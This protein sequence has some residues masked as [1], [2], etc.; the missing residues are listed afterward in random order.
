[1]ARIGNGAKPGE[2]RRLGKPNKIK[3]EVEDRL[4]AMK[5]DPIEGM[6]RIAHMAETAFRD[7]LRELNNGE[8]VVV[9]GLYKDLALAGSMYKELAQYI[10]PKR[11]AI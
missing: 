3:K 8:D 5:C 2:A 9:S 4:K 7:E 6:A 10:A 1:M 11:K